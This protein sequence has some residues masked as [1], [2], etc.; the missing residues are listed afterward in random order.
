MHLLSKPQ[1]LTTC[2]LSSLPLLPLQKHKVGLKVSV[3]GIVGG[4]LQPLGMQFVNS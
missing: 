3:G 2:S 4:V 1:S